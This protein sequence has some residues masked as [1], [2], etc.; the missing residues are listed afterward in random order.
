MSRIFGE[1]SALVEGAAVPGA[2]LRAM[3]RAMVDGLDL[4]V[5]VGGVLDIHCHVGRDADGHHL[6]ADDLVAD[7]HHHDIAQAVAFPANEPGEA[8]DFSAANAAVLDGA[9]RHP[10]RIVPFCRVDPARGAAEAIDRAAAG[11]ARGLKLHPV[12]QRFALDSSEAIAAVE[13][14]ADLGWPVLIHAGF[15]ARPI[16]DALARMLAAVRDARIILAH[17]ARGDLR[18]VLRAVADRDGI[19]FDTS[20]ALLPDLVALGPRRLCFGSDRPYG[21]MA[22]AY[23]LVARAAEV[24]GW[25]DDDLRAVLGET[26]RSVV[27]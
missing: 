1:D 15:A 4:P 26:A 16:A 23:L 9:G 10:G 12:A 5:P 25:G 20:L 17:G 14:A 27:A 8:G 11:G 3:E 6:S 21:D 24:G 2:D 13:R 22:T 18:D 7:L 19:Y